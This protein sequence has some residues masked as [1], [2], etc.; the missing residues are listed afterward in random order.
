MVNNE[1]I[2]LL[3]NIIFYLHQEVYSY[4][5]E[6]GTFLYFQQLVLNNYY[7]HTQ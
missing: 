4:L 2:E 1:F 6:M 3:K 7:M 5:N